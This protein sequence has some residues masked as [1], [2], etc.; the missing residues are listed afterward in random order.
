MIMRARR[1]L[2][3]ELWFSMKQIQARSWRL[4]FRPALPAQ[5]EK[6]V[7]LGCGDIDKQGFINIDGYPR[8]HVHYV[9]RIDNL[10]IFADDSIHFV[11]VSHALEHFP[12]AETNRVLSEWRRVLT[13]GGKLCLSVPDFDTILAMYSFSGRSIDPILRPLM[14][15]Q[16][17]RYN[18]HFNVFN[19]ESLT[20][21]LLGSGFD[22]VTEWRPGQHDMHNFPDWAGRTLVVNGRRFRISL[23]L[24]ATK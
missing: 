18:F 17:Y 5:E 7:H 23:N 19:R 1:Q 20:T 2:Y 4:F 14:G 22:S 15:G 16:D 6:W 24:E 8:A 9:R 12:F 21:A 3:R 13:K 11:Y 10:S